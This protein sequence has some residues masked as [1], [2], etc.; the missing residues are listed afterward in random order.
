MQRVP[1]VEGEAIELKYHSKDGEEVSH[2]AGGTAHAQNPATRA[3]KQKI[4]V[5][6]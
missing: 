1:S 3:Q 6:N 4:P 2:G 5:L